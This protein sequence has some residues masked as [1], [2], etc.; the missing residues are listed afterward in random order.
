MTRSALRAIPEQRV[1][2]LKP[3]RT[4]G[5]WDQPDLGGR[6]EP[7][8]DSVDRLQRD[9]RPD[10]RAAEQDVPGRSGLSAFPAEARRRPGSRSVGADRR[11]PPPARTTS[12]STIWRAA[13][14]IPTFVA[15]PPGRSSTANTSASAPQ[16][17]A[18]RRD[19]RRSE[20]EPEVTLSEWATPQAKHRRT[21]VAIPVLSHRAGPAPPPTAGTYGR[22]E[23]R[24]GRI[25]PRACPS[26]VERQGQPIRAGSALL[27]CR[28]TTPG[29]PPRPP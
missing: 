22:A 11:A 12:D 4:H 23:S 18:E 25:L 14:T 8:T 7:A 24:L 5:L 21:L 15:P 2:L 26:T 28:G 29:S 20:E 16:L 9:D 27:G 6:H 1:R 17:V 10:R 3:P 13:S 19:R